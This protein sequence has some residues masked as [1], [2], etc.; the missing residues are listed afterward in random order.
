MHLGNNP[1]IPTICIEFLNPRFRCIILTRRAFYCHAFHV[2]EVSQ[3]FATK[4]G[5]EIVVWIEVDLHNNSWDTLF[6]DTQ[7]IRRNNRKLYNV[8]SGFSILLK[9]KKKIT[10]RDDSLDRVC[11]IISYFYLLDKTSLQ[12]SATISSPGGCFKAAHTD[13]L[14]QP[15]DTCDRILPSCRTVPYRSAECTSSWWWKAP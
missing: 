6:H 10:A 15:Y 2:A 4:S 3:W 5:G 11:T 7:Q 13:R 8:A 12:R 1:I 14:R 9:K